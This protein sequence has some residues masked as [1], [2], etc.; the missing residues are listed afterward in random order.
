MEKYRGGTE[1]INWDGFPAFIMH[2][3]KYELWVYA[4]LE[5][6]LESKQDQNQ[7]SLGDAVD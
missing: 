1:K 6:Q 3:G 4:V 2:T 5:T 7:Y